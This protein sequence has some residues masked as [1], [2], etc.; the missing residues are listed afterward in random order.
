MFVRQRECNINYK[1]EIALQRVPT[2]LDHLRGGLDNMLYNLETI[3][4]QQYYVRGQ[5]LQ[6]V[7]SYSRCTNNGIFVQ[8]NII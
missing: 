8:K 6:S 1:Y 4:R 7:V 2:K 3:R 5:R